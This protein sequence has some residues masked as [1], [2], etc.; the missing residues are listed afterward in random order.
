MGFRASIAFFLAAAATAAGADEAAA[1]FPTP[2]PKVTVSAEHES[3]GY[4]ATRTQTAT[5]TDT[6]LIDVPQAVSVVTQDL[7]RDQA[8][9][10][11][12]D[13]VRYVPG[14]GMA[15]GEGNRDT[16]VLRGNS[17]T[18]DFFLDGARDDVE[19][20]R[21]VYNLDRVEI[22]KGPNAMLFGRGG[23]GGVVNRVS[24][25]ADWQP[26]RELS[27]QGGSWENRRATADFGDAISDRVAARVM[28]VYENSGSYRDGV[29]FERTGIN[30]TLAFAAGEAT[31]VRVSYEYY[32][33]DRTAD[34]GL[35]SLDGRPYRTDASTF[36]GDPDRSNTRATVNQG[37]VT[38]DHAFSDDVQ[39]RNR[40]LYADYDKFYQSVFA[41][42]PV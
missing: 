25:Q 3:E 2:L 26:V 31:V 20:Y 24:R 29:G 18:S 8:M 34:R 10:A 12:A 37:W 1:T 11:M 9:T 27:L 35:P 15:Q 38:V 21:D 16:V 42:G 14:A 28:G 23:A 4:L 6:A 39:F 17:S 19:Y 5:K 13:I 32:D 30:P 36:F 33:Y 41:G 40:T 22:L 7:I